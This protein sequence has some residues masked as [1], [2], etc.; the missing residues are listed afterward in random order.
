MADAAKQPRGAL[1]AQ[2][3]RRAAILMVSVE[4][5][6]A[7]RMMG[8][9]SKEDQQHVSMEIARLEGQPPSKEERDAVLREFYNIHVAQQYVEHGGV[10]YARQ[11]LEKVLPAEEVRGIIDTIETSMR[12]SPFGF[13]QQ[14]DT[15]NLVNFISDEHPQTIALIIAHLET[16]QAAEVLQGLPA[17]KQQE[18][19]KRLAGME[20]TSPEVVQQ[21]EKALESKLAT[22]VTHE[23]R[24]AGGVGTAAEILNLVQRATERNILDGL[25]EESPQLVDQIRRL[26]FTFSDIL[27]VNDRG[28]QNVLKNI[29]TSHISLAL[30]AAPPELAEKFFRNMSK[31]AAELVKEEMEFMGPVRLSEVEAARQAIVDVVRRLEEQNEVIIEGRGGAAEV[32]V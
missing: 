21:V 27:R 28:V 31:R 30:K 10:G 22:F 32:I 8:Q 13:L 15:G 7:A 5:D 14:T 6:T 9:L 18:V 19:V 12:L 11:I 17:K 25:Q 29:D 1:D 20:N 2:G 23:F 24:K 3:T 26:M 16:P 4:Q